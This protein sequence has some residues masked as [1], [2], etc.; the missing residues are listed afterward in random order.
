MWIA[1]IMNKVYTD[2]IFL[3]EQIY[4]VKKNP[5]LDQVPVRVRTS[6]VPSIM[7]IVQYNQPGHIAG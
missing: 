5:Y 3:A 6:T 1:M 4:T 2:Y 7:E